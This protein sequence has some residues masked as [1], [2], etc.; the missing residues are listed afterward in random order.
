MTALGQNS[1]GT[2]IA[3]PSTGASVTLTWA[4]GTDVGNHRAANEDSYVLACPYFAVADGMG[5]HSAGD[6][7]SDCVVTSIATLETSGFA[8]LAALEGALHDAV[9]NL[10][11]K[12]TEDQQGAG[13]TV[14][15]LALMLEEGQLQWNSFNIGDS[16]VYVQMGE[17]FEQVTTDH[18]VVQQLVDAGT[19]TKE[20]ADYHPHA[21][22][23]TRAV[24]ILDEPVPDYVALPVLA[25]M[26]LLIASDGLTKELTDYGI[27]HLLREHDDPGAAADAM[28]AAALENGGRDNVTLIIVQVTAEDDSSSPIENTAE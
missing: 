28:L 10:K 9:T 13:T 23:I 26:R 11:S 14:T 27:Q 20:E 2:I 15:G 25:G 19:I 3:D 5:G 7:A 22:V 6:I 1:T 21:N 8:E 17:M 12:L 24:G 18:S 16:R 4:A